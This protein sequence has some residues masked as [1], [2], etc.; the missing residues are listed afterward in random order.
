MSFTYI[1]HRLGS[2]STGSTYADHLAM[3]NKS[4]LSQIAEFLSVPLPQSWSKDKMVDTL[5]RFVQDHPQEILRR[6]SLKE[7]DLLNDCITIGENHS[8][9]RAKRYYYDDV[10]MLL[11]VSVGE[12]KKARKEHYLLSDDLRLLFVDH[13]DEALQVAKVEEQHKKREAKQKDLPLPNDSQTSAIPMAEMAAKYLAD[14]FE[15]DYGEVDEWELDDDFE[16]QDYQEIDRLVACVTNE[17]LQSRNYSFSKPML[18]DIR[19]LDSDKQQIVL[20][21]FYKLIKTVVKDP[22]FMRRNQFIESFHAME[23]DDTSDTS[24]Y[25]YFAV[26]D[27]DSFLT[28]IDYWSPMDFFRLRDSLGKLILAFGKEEGR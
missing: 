18:D 16:T 27:M 20:R 5:V 22:M 4:S 15:E 11:F 28:E 25:T 3:V 21:Y 6:L 13:I 12:D 26:N 7:L 1:T 19:A 23:S 9:E 10:K 14:L 17:E 8:V 2:T 24:L